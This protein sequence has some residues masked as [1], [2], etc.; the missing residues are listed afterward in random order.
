M[1]VGFK[2]EVFY[3]VVY[4]EHGGT[5][6]GDAESSPLPIASNTAFL[7]LPAGVVLE[8]VDV[9]IQTAVTGSTDIDIGDNGGD[10][11][12]LVDGSADLTLG[13]PELYSGAGA[14]LA[15]GA[16]H[17]YSLTAATD[18]AIAVTGASTAGKL[19]V[20]FKGYRV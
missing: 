4:F 9:I 1:G 2:N 19:R 14:D 10:T 6:S 13:T 12:G 18:L 5:G 7:S 3:D 11:D 17:L 20:V 8:D 16:A 15:S